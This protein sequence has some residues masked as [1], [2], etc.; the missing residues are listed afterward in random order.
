MYMK[1]AMILFLALFLLFSR[2]ALAENSSPA[3]P[4]EIVAVLAGEASFLLVRDEGMALREST[5]P[6]DRLWHFLDAEEWVTYL[7]R[8]ALL[9][10]DGDGE[11]EAA[12]E[13]AQPSGAGDEFY[14][15][16][17]L[18]LDAQ[19]GVVY[20]YEMY[21]R[22]M[23]ELKADGSF[24]YSS[25][26]MDN[27]FAFLHFRPDGYDFFP[28]AYCQSEPLGYYV[29]G[30]ESGEEAFYAA[31]DAQDHKPDPAW[32]PFS[33]DMAAALRAEKSE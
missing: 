22:S 5:L 12:L 8:F 2:T 25:G 24:L 7:T 19:G 26:A 29:N 31:A 18:I 16:G 13:I 21:I 15:A 6:A 32:Q 3:L 17:Y 30:E 28:F 23:N 4:D 14:R 20:G 1:R 9:D 11:K 10:M 27:G 33:D